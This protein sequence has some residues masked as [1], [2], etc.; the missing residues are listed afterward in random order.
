RTAVYCDRVQNV[1][2]TANYVTKNVR[3]RRGVEMPPPEWNGGGDSTGLQM[4]LFQ[5]A[6]GPENPAGSHLEAP[7]QFPRPN[8]PEEQHGL[9]ADMAGVGTRERWEVR[10]REAGFA[11]K[12]HRLV[13]R[14]GDGEA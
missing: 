3:D 1:I 13:R 9:L 6:P 5:A 11:L 8:P 14:N 7:P 4:P 2:G 10:L 12:G